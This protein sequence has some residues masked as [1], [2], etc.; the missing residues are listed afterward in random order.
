MF[1][2]QVYTIDLIKWKFLAF[3]SNS[4]TRG[5]AELNLRLKSIST[6]LS[7]GMF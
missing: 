5:R 6:L 4:G 7:Y 2:V 1:T 3:H